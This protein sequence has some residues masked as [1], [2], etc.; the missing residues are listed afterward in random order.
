MVS[1]RFDDL[2]KALE[3]GYTSSPY[4]APLLHHH[5]RGRPGRGQVRPE[6]AKW[7]MKSYEPGGLRAAPGR[8]A[9]GGAPARGGL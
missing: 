1:Q 9:R 6:F 8:G 2:Y 4:D 5:R 3:L 7:M